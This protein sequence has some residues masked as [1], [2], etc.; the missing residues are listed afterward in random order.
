M[1]AISIILILPKIMLRPTPTATVE[2]KP[3]DA[4]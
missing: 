1:I 4:G 2:L 3:E